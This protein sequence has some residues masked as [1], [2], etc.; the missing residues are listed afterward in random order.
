MNTALH[1][2]GKLY[3]ID[4]MFTGEHQGY[5]CDFEVQPG[6]KMMNSI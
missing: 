2:T 4:L 6:E 1:Y 5:S 3:R